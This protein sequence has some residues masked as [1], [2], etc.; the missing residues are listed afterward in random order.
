MATNYQRGRA[1][2]Y[3]TIRK[4]EAMGY[5]C[6]RA[7][8]SKGLYDVV[9]VRFDGCVLVQCKL[10]SSGN[11]SEDENCSL[12]RDLP[13][14]PSTRKELWIFEA[15]KGLVE[16]RDLK[17]EKFDARTSDGKTKRDEA[18]ARAKHIKRSSRKRK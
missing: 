12:L 14:H 10:T 18:R 16:V 13:V 6:L 15:G 2:E 8:S 1:K 5:N 4:L 17:E 11:F 9:G 7:A 3:D